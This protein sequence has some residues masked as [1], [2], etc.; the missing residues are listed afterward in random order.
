V[1]VCGDY[2]SAKLLK[3]EE[4]DWTVSLYGKVEQNLLVISTVDKQTS[5]EVFASYV[6]RLILSM[7]IFNGFRSDDFLFT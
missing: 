1:V 3:A 7:V 5:S 6:K 2:N 4:V